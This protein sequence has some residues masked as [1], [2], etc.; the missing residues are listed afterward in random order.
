[1]PL[2]A[3]DSVFQ[4]KVKLSTIKVQ[5]WGPFQRLGKVGWPITLKNW[6]EITHPSYPF[7][8]FRPFI[9]AISYNSI[10][11]DRLGL[12]GVATWMSQEARIKG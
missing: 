11:N 4:A 3:Y 12:L 9:W 2:K 7:I 10:Y 1:M 6:G 5:R 8:Y